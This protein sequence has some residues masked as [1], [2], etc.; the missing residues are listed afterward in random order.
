ME[1]ELSN[2]VDSMSGFCEGST[3]DFQTYSAPGWAPTWHQSNKCAA[4]T[5]PTISQYQFHHPSFNKMSVLEL[6]RTCKKGF[7]VKLQPDTY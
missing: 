5:I 4:K 2:S 3:T 6:L 7:I 1:D